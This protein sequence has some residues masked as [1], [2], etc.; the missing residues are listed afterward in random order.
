LERRFIDA[1]VTKATD[2]EVVT[3]SSVAL[4]S[5]DIHNVKEPPAVAGQPT[6][7]GDRKRG[8]ATSA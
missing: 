5:A 8:Q 6:E 1:K 2:D 3:V 4:A 7:K